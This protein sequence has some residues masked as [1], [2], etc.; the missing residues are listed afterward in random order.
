[1]TNRTMFVTCLLA[2]ATLLG[3]CHS[4]SKQKGLIYFNDFEDIKG[5]A[6]GYCFTKAPVH[7][8]IFAC[9]LDSAHVYGPTLRLRFDEISQFPVV[10]LK[11]S[12][13]CFLKNANS[14]GKIVV[15]I[16]NPD[17]KNIYWDAKHIP[18][19]T[20]VTGQWV[21]LKGEFVVTKNE[22]NAPLNTI[23]VYPWN[24]SKDDIYVDDFRVEFVQ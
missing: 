15:S 11:Y 16:D 12:I 18:D 5:W 10:K 7:S 17:H 14:I 3:A 22:V 8:G 19:L 1:M 21:E 24:I 2:A 9:K 6:S 13:W 4:A 20:K 23:S